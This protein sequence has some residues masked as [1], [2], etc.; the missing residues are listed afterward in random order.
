MFD[1]KPN[2]IKD[3]DSGKKVRRKSFVESAATIGLVSGDDA[4]CM[5]TTTT[6]QQ[7]VK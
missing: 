7:L 3:P 6:Y 2:K 5:R 4:S 1:V